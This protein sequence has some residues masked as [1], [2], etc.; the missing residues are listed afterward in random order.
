[1]NVLTKHL[2]KI[3]RFTG[4]KDNLNIYGYIVFSNIVP[5]VFD[6]NRLHKDLIEFLTFENLDSLINSK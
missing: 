4:I 1:M 6:N 2:D 5:M 3:S